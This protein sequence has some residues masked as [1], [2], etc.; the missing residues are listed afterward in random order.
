MR[1][2]AFTAHVKAVTTRIEFAT[3]AALVWSHV[4]GTLLRAYTTT[5]NLGLNQFS[6]D[7][8][9]LRHIAFQL[10]DFFF[11]LA[12]FARGDGP[13]AERERLIGRLSREDVSVRVGP[14]IA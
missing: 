10:L 12:P 11:P 14:Y 2:F 4:R 5:S 9:Q 3:R 13:E 1:L 8:L 6:I 7:F